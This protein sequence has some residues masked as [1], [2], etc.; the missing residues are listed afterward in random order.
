[1]PEFFEISPELYDALVDWPKR[2]ANETPF[3]RELFQRAGVN[4]VLDAACGTGQHVNLF[5]SWGLRT[6]GADAS[7]SM[8]EYCRRQFG[9]S[10]DVNWKARPFQ[11]PFPAGNRPFD[12]VIC[13]GNSL[14]LADRLDTCA[15]AVGAMLGCLR[16]GGVAVFQVLNLW[17]FAAG[18]VVWQPPR[19]IFLENQEHVLLRG[20]HRCD[21]LGY[22]ELLDFH[23][24]EGESLIGRHQAVF[25]GLE[26]EFLVQAAHRAGATGC[27][28][29]GSFQGEAYDREQSQ[30]LIFVCRK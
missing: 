9:D 1:M 10:A 4:A 24:V 25:H 29:F 22:L 6:E 23:R 2:L 18:P 15:Q 21:R 7:P 14:A 12:A 19:K 16:C 5:R 30:D 26:A 13:A 8:V 27:E 3:Y 28:V 20:L 17:R 11:E